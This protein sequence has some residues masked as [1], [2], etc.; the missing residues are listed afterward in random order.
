M[1]IFSII[2]IF[3]TNFKLPCDTFI[4]VFIQRIRLCL[5]KDIMSNLRL[6]FMHA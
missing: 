3:W 4:V 2:W 5:K 1:A 6:D